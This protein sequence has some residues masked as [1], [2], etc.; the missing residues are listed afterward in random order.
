MCNTDGSTVRP[1][2]DKKPFMAQTIS[3]QTE[4][5]PGDAEY[6]LAEKFTREGVLKNNYFKAF[7]QYMLAAKLG[8]VKAQFAIATAYDAGR[9]IY[10]NDYRALIWFYVVHEINEKTSIDLK[11]KAK[12]RIDQIEGRKFYLTNPEMINRARIEAGKS[13]KGG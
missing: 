3:L 4:P 12:S 13:I 9:G 7:K 5:E 11:R 6:A 10:K 1:D 8:H 2:G